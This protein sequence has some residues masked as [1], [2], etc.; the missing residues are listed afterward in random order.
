MPPELALFRRAVLVDRQTQWLGTVLLAPRPSNRLFVAVAVLT[1]AS[2]VALLCFGSYTRKARINGWLMPD[3]GL[4]RV[5]AGRA[6]VL[7]RLYVKQG[8]E[9]AAGAP[10]AE[11]ATD[12]QS[13]AFGDTNQR[14]AQQLRTQYDSLLTEKDRQRELFARQLADGEARLAALANERRELQQGVELQS[15]RV[16]LA[17]TT[18]VRLRRLRERQLITDQRLQAAEQDVLDQGVRSRE[19]QRN[20][21]ALDQ[22]VAKLKGE[23]GTIPLSEQMQINKIDRDVAGVEQ[24]LATAESSRKIV[25]TAPQAGTIGTIEASLGDAVGTS[26]PLLTILPKGAKLT[27]HLF[28][29]SRTIGFVRPGQRVLLRYAAFPYQKFGFYEGRVAE[30]SPAAFSAS[31]LPQHLSGLTSLYE[32][33][34]PIYRVTVNL[35]EQDVTAYGQRVALQPGMQLEGDVQL[36]RRSL[37]E[38]IFDPLFALAR[39]VGQ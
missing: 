27:A 22:E 25:L 24:Q 10:L 36:E 34:E 38:W 11:L 37:A 4:V 6:G 7:A 1:I 17:K 3:V 26:L 16:Q 2:L 35:A 5:V 21:A 20:L 28:S 15:D 23:L 8:E 9:V 13:E 31:E 12:V 18:L 30:I 39:E 33:S 29:S 19:Y 32:S 14:I